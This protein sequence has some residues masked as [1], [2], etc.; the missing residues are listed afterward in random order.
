MN[1]TQNYHLPQWAAE[2]FIKRD[3]FNDAFAAIDAALSEKPFVIGTYV[4]NGKTEADGGQQIELGFRPRM[5]ISAQGGTN[6]GLAYCS[7]LIATT[8]SRFS[9]YLNASGFVAYHTNAQQ[10][11]VNESGWTYYYIAFR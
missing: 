11:D 5:V 10:G 3:D 8:T 6:A 9:G 7:G 2:D 1:D 4:G